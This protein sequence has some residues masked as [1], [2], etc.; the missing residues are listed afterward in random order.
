MKSI[1]R[2]VLLTA[3][4]DK[5]FVGM[6]CLIALTV[7]LGGFL[8][9]TAL[10][11]QPQMVSTYIAG[12]VRMVTVLGFVLFVCFHLRVYT[13]DA[14]LAYYFRD[15]L[16]CRPRLSCICLTVFHFCDDVVVVFHGLP[17][18]ELWRL[19]GVVIEFIP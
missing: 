15:F 1:I 4:R 14:D 19:F 18:L 16:F 8:G 7:L 11:E 2:Y 3:A 9:S 17:C 10:A 5:L 12:G 6:L 13:I